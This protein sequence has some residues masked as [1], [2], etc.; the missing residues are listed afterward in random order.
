M[1]T[2]PIKARGDVKM[3]ICHNDGK[4]E[5]IEFPNTVLT[6]GRNALA[7]SLTNK[8]SGTYNYYINRMLFGNAGTTMGSL[9]YVDAS[10]NGLFCGNPI[11]SKPVISSVDSNV[12]SQAIFTSVLTNSDAVGE[13]LNEMALQMGTGDIYSMVT[14]PDFTKTDNMSIIWNWTL[15]FI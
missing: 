14:F 3:T 4:L 6:R 5:I 13:T 8:F 15:S 7:A 9:K 10:R 12:P 11:V 2:S 1:Q